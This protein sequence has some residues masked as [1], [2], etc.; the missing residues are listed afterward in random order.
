MVRTLSSK[1][2]TIY[3]FIIWRE[4]SV[5]VW[6]PWYQEGLPPTWKR[7]WRELCSA[8]LRC[9]HD[10]Q[11][12]R[13]HLRRERCSG[14]R[15]YMTEMILGAPE[16]CSRG[17]FPM[18]SA[19]PL[20]SFSLKITAPSLFSNSFTPQIRMIPSTTLTAVEAEAFIYS[21]RLNYKR[22]PVLVQRR[23]NVIVPDSSGGINSGERVHFVT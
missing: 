11:Q 13:I 10:G 3:V 6:L 12:A 8:L 20:C 9:T 17:G 2:K 5:S 1:I 15:P 21:F 18:Q 14:Y 7:G 19:L 16:T 22:G 23:L 4:P